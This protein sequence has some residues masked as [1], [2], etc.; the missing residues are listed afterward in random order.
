MLEIK[1]KKGRKNVITD[2]LSWLVQDEVTCKEGEIR[3]T[4]FD[5]SLLL[6]V[7]ILK[8]LQGFLDDAKQFV[9]NL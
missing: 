5:E 6:I 8:K 9:G 4:F 7:G 3:E 2:H 1:D